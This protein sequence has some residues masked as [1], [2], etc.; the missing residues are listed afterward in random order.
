MPRKPTTDK[1][2]ASTRGQTGKPSTERPKRTASANSATGTFAELV[3]GHP[4]EVRDLCE[5]VR[6]FILAEIP[7]AKEQVY[8]KGWRTAMYGRGSVT[9]CGLQ[10]NQGYVNFYL[11]HGAKLADPAHRLEGTGKLM[12][13]I[14]VRD[15]AVLK[16]PA[17]RQLLRAELEY[18]ASFD[19]KAG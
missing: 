2:S 9:A 15:A 16:D 13:H 18:A 4:P 11:L 7:D 5:K 8:P 19:G 3:K 14:K 1:R 17:V 6:A 12:R 10:P